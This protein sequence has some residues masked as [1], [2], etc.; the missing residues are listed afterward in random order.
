MGDAVATVG[1][2][3]KT[4]EQNSGQLLALTDAGIRQITILH[5]NRPPLVRQRFLVLERRLERHAQAELRR[6]LEQIQKRLQRLEK[7]FEF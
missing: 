2:V 5:L 7:R 4:L 6:E 1:F 3:K